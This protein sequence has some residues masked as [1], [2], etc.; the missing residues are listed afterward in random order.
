[1]TDL[2]LEYSI[3]IYKT[4]FPYSVITQGLGQ[5]FETCD[6]NTKDVALCYLVRALTA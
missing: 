1:L 4:L 5:R 2:N 3:L 6:W